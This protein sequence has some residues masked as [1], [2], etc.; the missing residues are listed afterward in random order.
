[1]CSGVRLRLRLVD[2]THC[3]AT[4]RPA[5]ACLILNVTVDATVSLKLTFSAIGRVQRRRRWFA[6]V[7]LTQ[8][9]ATTRPAAAN[10]LGETRSA[11]S[12][13]VPPPGGIRA[14]VCGGHGG[15]PGCGVQPLTG[16]DPT[17]GP[18]PGG[19]SGRNPSTI[20]CV[21]SVPTQTA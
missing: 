4:R 6:L 20:E 2:A 7:T 18:G 13:G 8:C 12:D 16:G 11:D 1:M 9:P 14:S 21:P 15:R 17:G 5:T 3:L 10:V 19:G